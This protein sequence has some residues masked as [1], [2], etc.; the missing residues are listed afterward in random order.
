MRQTIL[1]NINV[2]H[3]ASEKSEAQREEITHCHPPGKGQNKDLSPGLS[4]T[5]HIPK[6]SPCPSKSHSLVEKR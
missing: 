1:H 4:D 6:M 3:F 2:T 5:Y